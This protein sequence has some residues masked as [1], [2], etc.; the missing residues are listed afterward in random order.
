MTTNNRVLRPDFRVFEICCRNE[1]NHVHLKGRSINPS[2][3]DF[4][5]EPKLDG[6]LIKVIRPNIEYMEVATFDD[7]GS[8]CTS[9]G[10]FVGFRW[11]Q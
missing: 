5:C 10:L 1:A 11:L 6:F 2:C 7:S 9:L 4:K 8:S 3:L